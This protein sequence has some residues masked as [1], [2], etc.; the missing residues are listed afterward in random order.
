MTEPPEPP[1]RELIAEIDGICRKKLH[2]CEGD[3]SRWCVF[4]LLASA[5][6]LLVRQQEALGADA[7]GRP[8]S[9]LLLAAADV[10]NSHGGGPLEDCLRLKSAEIAALTSTPSTET[11]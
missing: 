4:C 3:V 8:L 10:C 5:R 2:R 6:R 1:L 11:I 9:D 7:A